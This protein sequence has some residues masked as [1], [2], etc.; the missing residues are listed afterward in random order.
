MF[1]LAAFL[2]GAGPLSLM[3]W[4]P[5]SITALGLTDRLFYLILIPVGLGTA[6]FLFGVLQSYA[7]YSGHALGGGIELGGPIVATALVVIG[8]FQLPPGPSTFPF[9][10]YVH[11]EAGLEDLVLKDNGKVTLQLGVEPQSKPI[12]ENGQAYFPAIS[13]QFR[14]K[15]ANTLVE[16]DGFEGRFWFDTHPPKSVE[17]SLDT[18]EIGQFQVANPRGDPAL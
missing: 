2:L 7:V 12:R 1:S 6:C 14:G 15:E 10:V 3:I 11:G 8:G 18:L 17:T 4:K 16:A 5:E 13:S 9:T